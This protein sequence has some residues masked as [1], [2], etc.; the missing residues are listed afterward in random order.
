[1]GEI[2]QS[3]I[4]ALYEKKRV[5]VTL[6]QN[7]VYDVTDFMEDHPGGA[8]LIGDFKYQDITEV[9]ADKA[10]HDHS[11]SAY[12]V[13]QE[14]VIGT[15]P[16][17]VTSLNIVSEIVT[18]EKLKE[19]EKKYGDL[20]SHVLHA[21]NTASAGLELSD[22]RE[23]R[24]YDALHEFT[25]SDKDFV[26][27]NF[28]DLTK[29]MLIQVMTSNWSRDFYIQQVHKPR[30]YRYGSAPI[31]GNFLGP[32][33]LTPWWMIPIIWL[34]VNFYLQSLAMKGNTPIQ[35]AGYFAFGVALWTLVEYFLHRVLFHLD[36]Y[37]PENR[38]AITLHFLMHGVHHYLP[39]DRMRLVMPP[40]MCIILTTPLYFL[41]HFVFR[42]Y[43]PSLSI[44]CGAQFG[45][46][47]YDLTHYF[48]HH[49]QLPKFMKLIKIWHLDHH[50][51]DFQRGFG[52]TSPFWDYVFGSTY[53]DTSAN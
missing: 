44:F 52:V 3:E 26:D 40:A 14:Y 32:L 7:V 24:L 33:S 38:V 45:Y 6:N 51:R 36:Y 35:H 39:M 2:N 27:N 34:P 43:Y 15:L 41:C 28:I 23:K 19:D 13:L 49:K 18:T 1:M 21:S 8:D 25:D 17:G 37:L 9:M 46:I 20:D 10:L 42:S 22:E 5:L 12:V 30:H 48:I 29:P 31:F 11:D 53:V 4:N 16:K 50:Y 47:L